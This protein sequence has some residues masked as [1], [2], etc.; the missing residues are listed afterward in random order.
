MK[1]FQENLHKLLHQA[2][3]NFGGDYQAI[4]KIVDEIFNF[5]IK[6]RASD[7]HIEPLEDFLRIRYRID[8]HL[9]EFHE[10]IP[11]SLANNFISRIKILARM[12]T[13]NNFSPL[14]GAIQ[15]GNVEMRVATI[16]T[17]NYESLTIRVLD[18]SKQLHNLSDLGFSQK[19]LKIFQKAISAT[20]GMI[21]LTG[22]MNSGKSTTLYAALRELNKP[23]RSIM[24]LEDPIEQNIDG[25]TQVQI[26]EK[27]GLNF[28]AGLRAM[29]RMDAN[30]LMVGESRDAETSR[31]AV[32]AALTGHLI[33]TTLHA[34]DSC[35]AVFRMI[36][37]GVEPYLL[38]STLKCVVAQRLVRKICPNCKKL[39]PTNNFE[40]NLLNV[41]SIFKP[42]GC[43]ICNGTGYL[44]R[45][46]LHEILIVEKSVRDL[47]LYSKDLDKIRDA[48]INSGLETLKFDAFE[49]IRAGLTTFEEVHRILGD[50]L[51]K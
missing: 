43:E 21:I 12:D 49:K 2:R 33:F 47:I 8:G 45:I 18:T 46:A 14:D 17:K 23:S 22:P 11:I 42:V 5:A 51:L 36:E 20:S 39:V 50:E 40:K 15:F 28:A 38:A 30:C 34:G 1:N 13:T 4:A 24:T 29:L 32:R 44:G 10:K 37:M 48:A 6:I 9:H 16:P 41:E 31:I 35:S 19:N 26:N 7:I 27:V 3:H 25:I